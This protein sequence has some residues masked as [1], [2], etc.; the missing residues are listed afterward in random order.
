MN[1]NSS[2]NWCALS[3]GRTT[4]CLLLLATSTASLALSPGNGVVSSDAAAAPKQVQANPAKAGAAPGGESFA[5]QV[6]HA[7]R[8]RSSRVISM[9]V[10]EVPDVPINTAIDIE[11]QV[12][13]MILLPHSVRAANYQLRAQI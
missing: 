6:N 2:S 8:L 9:Q 10:A 1:T 13:T 7:F 11:G 4:L 3:L 5:D 12:F